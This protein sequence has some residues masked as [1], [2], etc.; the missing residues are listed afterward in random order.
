MPVASQSVSEELGGVAYSVN[1]KSHPKILYHVVL[2]DK[3]RCQRYHI[4][5]ISTYRSEIKQ[6]LQISMVSVC[7]GKLFRRSG[8]LLGDRN[9][10]VRPALDQIRNKPRPCVQCIA[11]LVCKIVPLVNAHDAPSGA[12]HMV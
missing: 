1:K 6:I 12:A 7:E 2:N 10:V 11:L 9:N 5:S 8:L 4:L 3:Y